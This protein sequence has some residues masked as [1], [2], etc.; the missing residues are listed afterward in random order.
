MAR[1]KRPKPPRRIYGSPPPHTEC[2]IAVAHT[3]K[4]ATR[5]GW[6]LFCYYNFDMHDTTIILRTKDGRFRGRYPNQY[7][8]RVPGHVN[9]VD[10]REL[11]GVF[12]KAMGNGQFASLPKYLGGGWFVPPGVKT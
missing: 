4:E 7:L 2:M 12:R 8:F 1:T 11:R 5:R 9:G 6:E 3:S 10:W